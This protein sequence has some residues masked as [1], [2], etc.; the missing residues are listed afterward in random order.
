MFASELP[1]KL[2]AKRSNQKQLQLFQATL[3]SHFASFQNFRTFLHTV[4]SLKLTEFVLTETQKL[5]RMNK[6]KD[7][8]HWKTRSFLGVFPP[9]TPA[10]RFAGTGCLCTRTTQVR[11][12]TSGGKKSRISKNFKVFF[13]PQCLKAWWKS[14]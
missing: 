6:V 14:S 4:P 8:H 2:S 5:L 9:P 7:I 11:P 1:R 10:L 13:S 12:K 3:I